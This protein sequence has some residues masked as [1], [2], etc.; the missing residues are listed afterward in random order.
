M[1]L[2]YT[3]PYHRMMR[4][5]MMNRM[6]DED[7]SNLTRVTFPMD[8]KDLE[9]AYEITALLPGVTADDLNIQCVNDT[10]TIQGEL[11]SRYNEQDSY[12][13]HEIPAGRFMRA[14]Q[15]PESVDS[16]RVDASLKDGV[17]T[18]T[19]PKAEEARPKTIKIT[20]K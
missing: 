4:R 20:T 13:V 15:L 8:V 19:I 5:H 14:V 12:L 17:L 2:Y 16:A 6:T 1:A 7:W 18:L 10:I 3:T 9:E 11:K